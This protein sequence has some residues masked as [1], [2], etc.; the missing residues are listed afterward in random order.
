[1]D[2]K[3]MQKFRQRLQEEYQKLLRSISRNRLAEEEIK[4]ENT[5]DE[6]DLA[7]ISHNKEL[8]YNLHESDF[9]RLR[10]IGE[11]IKALDRGQ[12]GKCVHC[13]NDINERRLLAV[14][15]A[16]LCIR[17]QEETEM[18]DISSRLVLAG[19]DEQTDF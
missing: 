7:T 9:A 1:M 8:L 3:K 16:A 14:P 11:V 18:S 5:E 4:L 2:D 17:C 19:E 12:Y 10:F 15:W 6:G 13:G